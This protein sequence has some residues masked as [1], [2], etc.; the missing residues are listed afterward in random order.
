MASLSTNWITE[1]HI[2]FEYKK[3][4]LLAYLQHV[5][6]NFVENKL[7]PSLSE[8]MNHYRHVLALRD[9]KKNLLES[10]PERLVTADLKNFTLMY[11]K[12]LADDELMKEIENIILFSIPQFEKH[13]SEGKKIYDF[14]EAA[15]NIYPV[16]IVPLSNNEGYIFLTTKKNKETRIYEYQVTLFENP[17]EKFRGICTHYICSY[18]KSVSNTFENIKLDLLKY[19]QKLVNPATYVIESELQ[20]PLEETFLPLAKRSLIKFVS[21][22]H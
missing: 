9:G 2:D 15:I 16:G 21:L 8:L 4:V 11:E 14:I 18:E 17:G 13:I 10:F 3:Y 20:L 6:E 5:N 7:Y 22:A 1:K 19:Q 12:I